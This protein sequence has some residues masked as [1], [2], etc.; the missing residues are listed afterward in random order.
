MTRSFVCKSGILRG[1]KDIEGKEM[2]CRAKIGVVTLD[3][4][5]GYR[6]RRIAI[7][8]KHIH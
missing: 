4:S 1:E 6:E 3:R 5:R 7:S 8:S 2:G